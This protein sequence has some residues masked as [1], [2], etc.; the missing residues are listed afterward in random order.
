MTGIGHANNTYTSI[1]DIIKSHPIVLFMKGTASRPQCG[2]SAAAVGALLPYARPGP[3]TN[4]LSDPAL[5]PGIKA[6]LVPP[7][8]PHPYIPCP[9]PG[10]GSIGPALYACP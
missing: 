5:P 6:S 10:A 9:S 7:P 3:T 1:A 4:V 8:I 2:F